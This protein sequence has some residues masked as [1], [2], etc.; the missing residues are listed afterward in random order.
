MQ[1]LVTNLVAAL[2]LIAGRPVQ[3]DALSSTASSAAI[4]LVVLTVV[5]GA[6]AFFAFHSLFAA[7][8]VALFAVLAAFTVCA[9]AIPGIA[10]GQ[11]I[12]GVLAVAAMRC[13]VAMVP[14]GDLWSDSPDWLS[15][16][17]L[18]AGGAGFLV[19]V[20]RLTALLGAT[21]PARRWLATLA[22]LVLVI[23]GIEWSTVSAVM[24]LP[25]S[26]AQAS[27]TSDSETQ[28]ARFEGLPVTDALIDQRGRIAARFAALPAHGAG[29][30][31]FTITI[32]GTG[33]QAIFDREARR[34]ADVLT[35]RTPGPSIVLS[36][37]PEQV[38]HGILASPK[39]VALAIAAIGHRAVRGDTL[40]IYLASH[41]GREA[42]IVME[43]PRL[44]FA[45]L[46]A[47]AL[48]TDLQR[49][50]IERRIVI[51]SACFG[52]TWI[53]P[54]ANPTTILMT[55]ANVDRTSFGCDD[56]RDLTVFGKAI[57]RELSNHRQSLAQAFS[58]AKQRIATD[59]HADHETPSQP[60]SWVGSEMAPVWSASH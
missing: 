34:A 26:A 39:T 59:E 54:L 9:I 55:A 7:P 19:G 49:A 24:A 46:S 11:A 43:A 21:S 10:T 60:Q 51:V 57:L 3:P 38:T 4:L 14:V 16:V 27:E 32:G 20:W 13:G 50:G 48:A 15:T 8:V 53:K 41:G 47:A 12:I 23:F 44:D 2:R 25:L 17:L 58:R 28:S 56:S 52:A 18:L 40:V 6:D 37:S 35:A 33:Y 31:T 45:D 36:N 22:G 29:P 30:E 1:T 5:G 42:N